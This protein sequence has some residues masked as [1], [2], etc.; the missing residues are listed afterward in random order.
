VS[1]ELAIDRAP[2]LSVG[3]VFAIGADVSTTQQFEVFVV[4]SLWLIYLVARTNYDHGY[5]VRIRVGSY[6]RVALWNLRAGLVAICAGTAGALVS[7]IA[8]AVILSLVRPSQNAGS[9]V[10]QPRD[11]LPSV[12]A[13][14]VLLLELALLAT[15]LLVIQLVTEAIRARGER[16]T[17]IAAFV[18]ALW[19]WGAASASGFTPQVSVLNLNVFLDAALLIH[20]HVLAIECSAAIAVLAGCAIGYVRFLDVRARQASSPA[21]PATALF[22]IVEAAV[23]GLAVLSTRGPTQSFFSVVATVLGGSVGSIISALTTIIV[24]VGYAFFFQLRASNELDG[25]H[26]VSLIRRGSIR[27]FLR[28]TLAT[29]VVR[30]TAYLGS[31]FV[32]A[33]AA[34]VVS[35][36]ADFMASPGE[37]ARWIYQYLVNG[38]LQMIV[39][40]IFV[41]GAILLFRSRLAGLVAVGILTMGAWIPIPP[42]W[43]MPLQLSRLTL[44]YEGWPRVLTASGVLVATILALYLALSLILKRAP[45]HR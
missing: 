32:V 33:I 17:A 5:P 23:L 21:V 12:P 36:G 24:V 18:A 14:E 3:G 43:L 26:F 40:V 7:W 27:Q 15:T 37:L 13:L 4:L 22:V 41:L 11:L 38:V 8:A 35:G 19:V 2:P 1:A 29:E 28:S 31:L 30:A 6:S 44:S 34:Y 9:G 39:Y 25:W 10:E 42:N 45:Q 20:N 16:R